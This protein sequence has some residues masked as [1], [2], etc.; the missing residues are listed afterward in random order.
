MIPLPAIAA[1]VRPAGSGDVP[2][3]RQPLQGLPPLAH[4]RAAV[5]GPTT[6]RTSG[7]EEHREP[8]ATGSQAQ[9]HGDEQQE[10]VGAMVKRS[11][12]S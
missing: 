4:A 12:R 7:G 6:T 11:N 3:R 1:V 5:T 8:E 9:P 10:P 2:T